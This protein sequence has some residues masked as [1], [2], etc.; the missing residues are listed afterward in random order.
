MISS[1]S[2]RLLAAAGAGV[3]A[4]CGLGYINHAAHESEVGARVMFASFGLY[5]GLGALRRAAHRRDPSVVASWGRSALAILGM[6]LPLA[7]RPEGRM[8]WGGGWWVAT[9]GA[10][11]GATSVVAL[12]DCFCIAPALR[13]IVGRGPY[14]LVRHPMA[15]AFL[16]IAAGCLTVRWSPW[17]A[18]AFGLAA[19]VGVLTLVCEE[20]LLRKDVRYREYASRVPW[21]LVPGVV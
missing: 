9:A 18:V 12:G 6:L 13:G 2:T 10:I 3:Y 20:D 15:A 19:L 4:A 7:V 16:V 17:N 14:R 8:L 1:P 5:A 21:W 11:L